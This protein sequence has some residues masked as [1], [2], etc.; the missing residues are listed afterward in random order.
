MVLSDIKGKAAQRGNERVSK[1]TVD[2]TP[3]CDSI[4][5]KHEPLNRLVGD[6]SIHNLGDVRDR[7]PPVEKVIRFD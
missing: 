1:Q 2:V 4:L 7:D 6:E 5:S 3:T